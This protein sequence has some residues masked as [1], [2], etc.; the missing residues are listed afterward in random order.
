[1]GGAS[2]SGGNDTDVSGAEAVATGRTTYANK[3]IKG[4]KKTT[5]QLN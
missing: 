2:S 1:M 5:R 4:R 3:K